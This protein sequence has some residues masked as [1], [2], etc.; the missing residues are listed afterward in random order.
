MGRPVG[1]L[2]TGREWRHKQK[3]ILR[4]AKDD[5]PLAKD[6]KPLAKDDKPLAKDDESLTKDDESLTKMTRI[7]RR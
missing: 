2:F 5:K 7:W 3:Q 1:W 4:C 6:D